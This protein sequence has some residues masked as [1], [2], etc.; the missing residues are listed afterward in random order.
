MKTRTLTIDEIRNG[1]MKTTGTG[2]WR[3]TEGRRAWSVAL[4]RNV[5]VLRVYKHTATIMCNDLMAERGQDL[6]TLEPP[7]QLLR[8]EDGCLVRDAEGRLMYEDPNA[9]G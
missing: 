8:D 7:R 6:A 3:P 2:T 4:G 5:D 1:S 9:D